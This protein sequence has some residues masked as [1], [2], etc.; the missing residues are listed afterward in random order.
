MIRK[1][2]THFAAQAADSRI[3]PERRRAIEGGGTG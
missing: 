1:I 3:D 2:K